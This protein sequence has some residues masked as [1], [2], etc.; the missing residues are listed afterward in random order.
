MKDFY[1]KALEAIK[2]MYS[3]TTVPED[4]TIINL[5]ALIMEINILIDALEGDL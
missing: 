5:N 1:E 4:E 2:A 3:D